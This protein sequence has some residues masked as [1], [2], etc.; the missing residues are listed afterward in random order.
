[1]ATWN[2]LSGRGAGLGGGGDI[3]AQGWGGYQPNYQ[4]PTYGGMT[5]TYGGGYGG[6]INPAGAADDPFAY[7]KGSLLTPW[8]GHFDSSGFGG[9]YAVPA[10]NPFQFGQ[11]NYKAPDVGAFT[12]QYQDP[13]AFRFADFNGPSQFQAPTAE[14]MKADPA[15]QAR[16]D[17]AMN[18]AKAAGASSGVLR[19]GGFVKGLQDRAQ[20]VAS[21]E[22]GNIY[23][24][25]QGEWQQ[26]FGRAKDIYG[27][28]QGNTKTAFD[29]NVRNK[30]D[31]YGARQSTWK[32]NADVG[33]RQGELGYNIATGTYDRNLQLARQQYEDQASHDA[34]V[35][36][37]ANAGSSQNY[38]RSLDDYLRNR[39]EFWTNQ[40]RQYALLDREANRGMDAA[41][42][43]GGAMMG[44]YGNMA[45]AAI[46]QG[47]ARASGIMGSGN[48]WGG[49]V[50]NMGGLAGGALMYGT[51]NPYGGSSSQ[52]RLPGTQFPIPRAPR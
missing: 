26:E 2:D 35:A 24:R 9:G 51:T 47:D 33:L 12:E 38:N 21:Q 28:N 16:M 31:A 11:F 37:A 39:D 23:G 25:K 22:Y 32:D 36:S 3:A 34:A 30:L 17:A 50:S 45:N 40:D 41:N 1:M 19:T 46:G 52:V 18:Q 14:D 6:D 48:A 13:A 44:T 5:G 27:L 15:Y 49:A 43:Y 42:A 4:G 20:G 10:F 29:T 8:E 7:T